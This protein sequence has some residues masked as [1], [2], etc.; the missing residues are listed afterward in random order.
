MIYG[1]GK[2]KCPKC[3]FSGDYTAFDPILRDEVVEGAG[4]IETVSVGFKCPKCYFEF[5]SEE[6]IAPKN[7]NTLFNYGGKNE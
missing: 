1:K 2:A 3:S 6:K 7:Q 4:G 5:W